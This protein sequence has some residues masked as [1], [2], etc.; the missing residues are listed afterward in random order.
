VVIDKINAIK[1]FLV[2][3]SS[4][5]EI[6]GL[7]IPIDSTVEIAPLALDFD[8]R[9]IHASAP[10]DW[11]LLHFTESIFQ[12]RRELLGPAV[13]TGMVNFDAALRHHFLQI[14]VAERVS[15]IP[16]DTGQNNG[17]FDAVAFKVDHVVSL[18]NSLGV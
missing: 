14:P 11:A 6:D 12:L 9:F 10:A 3:M 8:I 15:Q 2:A 17:F 1:P 5:Q 7:A 16:T 18:C 13:N 4:Q